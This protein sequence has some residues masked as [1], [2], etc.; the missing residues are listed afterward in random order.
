MKSISLFALWLT[1]VTVSSQAI[2]NDECVSATV[3]RHQSLPFV[4]IVNTKL[5]TNNPD[6]P[7]TT[8]SYGNDGNTFWYKYK[9]GLDG[10][11]QVAT[12]APLD[13][14]KLFNSVIGVFSGPCVRRS[15]IICKDYDFH[16]TLWYPVTAEETYFIQV[17]AEYDYGDVPGILNFTLSFEPNY[18]AVVNADTDRNIGPLQD[19]FASK[20][21][22]PPGTIDYR[23]T[24]TS[25]LSI[26]AKFHSN[27]NATTAVR[28]VRF[29][30]DQ[31]RRNVCESSRPFTLFGDTNGNI[32][33]APFV[34]GSRMVTATPYTRS[35][36]RGTAGK[37]LSQKFTVVGC[38]YVNYAV[39]DGRRDKYISSLYNA[40]TV[41]SPP[42]QVNIGVE[43]VCGFIPGMVRL[44]L[45]NAV[46]NRMVVSTRVETTAPYFLFGDNGQGNINVG[47]IPAGEYTITAIIDGI[48]HPAVRFT[49]GVCN[50]SPPAVVDQT[51]HIDLRLG[52]D[53]LLTY[54]NSQ[55]F[56][57][58]VDRI[59]SLVIGDRPDV[60]V[61]CYLHIHM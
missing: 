32:A 13:D 42:C 34:I 50:P 54:E 15:E 1:T 28:S 31:P 44:E 58:A 52:L 16:D 30:L 37:R 56:A 43:F 24:T 61:R 23:Y 26:A 47:S 53:N 51:F 33:G 22:E 45:R 41:R 9:P 35:N 27:T 4:D 3:I 14:D 20:Y 7:I 38:E 11:I 6:D 59:S 36:C 57:T 10:L 12:D 19:L 29:T 46:N 21:F 49:M 40:S 8:C 2:S 17:G 5:A 60:S 39:Y 25:S 18:F 55:L 48:V